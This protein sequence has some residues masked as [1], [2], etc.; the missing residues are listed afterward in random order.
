MYVNISIGSTADFILKSREAANCLQ[1]HGSDD[2]M[3]ILQDIVF[4]HPETWSQTLPH[5]QCEYLY[6]IHSMSN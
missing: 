1:I 2:L 4:K 6:F 5:V 3:E